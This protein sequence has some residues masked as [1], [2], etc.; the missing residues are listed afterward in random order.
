MSSQ[1]RYEIEPVPLVVETASGTDI[2]LVDVK[3]LTKLQARQVFTNGRMRSEGEQ[4]AF[5]I[6]QAS[7]ER[8]AT[9]TTEIPAWTV[10]NGRVIFQK[11]ATLTAGEL[12]T[13]ITQITK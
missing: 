3:N 12:A 4:K 9:K 1:K 11:G 5:L 7:K 6:E 2:L 13:I 8:R 10:K